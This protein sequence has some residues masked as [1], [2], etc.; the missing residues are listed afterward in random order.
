MRSSSTS[1]CF[2][3]ADAI[4][5]SGHPSPP[6]QAVKLSPSSFNIESARVVVLFGHENDKLWDIVWDK[7]SAV[8]HFKDG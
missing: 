8:A 7:V 6:S 3:R 5:L 2:S 4:R 1:P